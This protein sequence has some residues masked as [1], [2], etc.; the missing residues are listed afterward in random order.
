[1]NLIKEVRMSFKNLTS[2]IKIVFFSLTVVSSGQVFA[3]DYL[4]TGN[5]VEDHFSSGKVKMLKSITELTN[6]FGDSAPLENILIKKSTLKS[7]KD[8]SVEIKLVG[9]N[10]KETAYQTFKNTIVWSGD[11]E[12]LVF[13]DYDAEKLNQVVFKSENEE[14]SKREHASEAPHG[15]ILTLKQG[16]KVL[17]TKKLNIDNH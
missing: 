10:K 16:T 12:Y 3:C 1:M 11:E 15:L 4:F 8:L 17:C 2:K 9:E 13:S 5:I 7:H 6:D 14:K